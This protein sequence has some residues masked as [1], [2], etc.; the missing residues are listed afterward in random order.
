MELPWRLAQ[1]DPSLPL[2][3][4]VSGELIEARAFDMWAGGEWPPW[5]PAFC[6][7][8]R[9]TEHLS[10]EAPPSVHSL[11]LEH[12]PGF[13]KGRERDRRVVRGMA[14]ASYTS[15]S[16]HLLGDAWWVR[17]WPDP[18]FSFLVWRTGV[19]GEGVLCGA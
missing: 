2:N 12:L 18:C 16:L 4:G 11:W 9:M 14:L 8:S 5:P 1:Q 6:L 10:P 13:G 19:D 17:P 3:P 15:R 7:C